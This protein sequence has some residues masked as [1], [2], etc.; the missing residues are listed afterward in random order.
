MA[1]F[2]NSLHY[3]VIERMVE[4]PLVQLMIDRFA[5]CH[6]LDLVNVNLTAFEEVWWNIANWN[7]FAAVDTGSPCA[8]LRLTGRLTRPMTAARHV[9]CGRVSSPGVAARNWQCTLSKTRD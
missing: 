3:H 4:H 1:L 5:A 8:G 9:S 6:E 2:D 7:R